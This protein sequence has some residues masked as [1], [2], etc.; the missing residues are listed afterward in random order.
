[1]EDEMFAQIRGWST[2]LAEGDQAEVSAAIHA[3]VDTLT[4]L[5]DS[6]SPIAWDEAILT[7]RSSELLPILLLDPFTRWS[8]HRPRGFPGDAGLIDFIY[9]QGEFSEPLREASVLGQWIYAAN[10]TRP[11]CKAV[12]YRKQI[13][14]E[15]LRE[16][17]ATNP[18][19]AALGIAA[20]HLRELETEAARGVGFDGRIVAL[21][22]D[23]TALDRINAR[24]PQVEC[25]RMT[26][27]DI[28]AGRLDGEQFDA[29]WSL[30]LYDY[31]SDAA[32]ERLL[33]KQI[34]LVRPGGRVM[35]CNFAP[36]A[37]DRGYMEA[38]MDWKLIYRDEKDMEALAARSQ[39]G[40]ATRIYR[41]PS[42][43]VVFLELVR[44]A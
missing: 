37:A 38:F 16:V 25:L 40:C 36:D 4:G 8:Y 30:G 1:M 14:A 42:G 23:P 35:I 28:L 32:A 18:R 9:A 5:R 11:A 29:T 2:R 34:A 15:F 12:R 26:V 17:M 13:A 24:L 41:E 31:L 27:R 3:M 7:L 21:D 19:P 22:Q 43:Q 6:L 39:G 44:N 20:G 33:A 10:Q